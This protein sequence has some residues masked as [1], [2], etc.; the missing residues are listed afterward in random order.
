MRQQVNLFL[1]MFRKERKIFSARTLLS[2][3][4]LA[5]TVL[6]LTYGYSRWQ[7]ARLDA[8]LAGLREQQTAIGAQLATLK[9]PPATDTS[10]LDARIKVLKTR[11]QARRQLVDGIDRLID[12]N[13]QGFAAQFE[14]LAREHVA[15][16]WL[17]GL[18]I[19][20]RHDGVLLKGVALKPGLVPAY[21]QQLPEQGAFRH[22]D[23]HTVELKRNGKDHRQI[24][25]VLKAGNS[26]HG[27]LP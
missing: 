2:I 24:D 12:A 1:P 4:T 21:L 23:F 5:V 27:L 6:L 13:R 25:F 17:T 16:L 9:P 15:G 26:A 11:L 20:R 8:T 7:L 18:Q 19:D 3:C 14:A 10:A 22:V